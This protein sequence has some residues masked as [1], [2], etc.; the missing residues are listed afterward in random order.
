MAELCQPIG[1]E[2][3]HNW[4]LLERFRREIVPLLEAAP[5]S[6]SEQDE[7]RTLLAAET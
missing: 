1:P 4:K 7:R 2:Q 6:A 3:L 5:R